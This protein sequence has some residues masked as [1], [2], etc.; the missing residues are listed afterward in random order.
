MQLSYFLFTMAD[1]RKHLP[2]Q[3]HL[4]LLGKTPHAPGTGRALFFFG[5]YSKTVSGSVFHNSA[6]VT[7][8]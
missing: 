2:K 1:N 8:N 5:V 7:F 4:N 3:L 6:S